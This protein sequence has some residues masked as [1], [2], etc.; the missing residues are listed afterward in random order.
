M[1]TL[2]APKNAISIYQG[3]SRTLALT[4]LDAGGDAVDLTGATAYM[5]VKKLLSDSTALVRK[6]STD[7]AQAS[8]VTPRAGKVEFYLVPADTK[9]LDA[10]RYVFDMWVQLASGSRYAV[11]TTSTFEVRGAVTRLS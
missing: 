8:I 11:V 10:G 2:L 7:V 1:S 5:T 9:T 3:A 6:A 4:V